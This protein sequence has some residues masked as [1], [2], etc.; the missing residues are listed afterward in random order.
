MPKCDTCEFMR[1]GAIQTSGGTEYEPYCSAGIPEEERVEIGE[2]IGCRHHHATLKKWEEQREQAE[3]DYYYEMGMGM[4]FWLDIEERPERREHCIA[5]MEH[6]IGM[7]HKPGGIYKR[8]GKRFYKPYRNYWSGTMKDWDSLVF[9]GLAEHYAGTGEDKRYRCTR[10]GL[11]WLGKQ[12]G[13]IIHD[14]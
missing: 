11:D 1:D 4:G 8:H 12:I 14:K 13:V 7:D 9:Y 3:A 6:C 5:I 2:E 10:K